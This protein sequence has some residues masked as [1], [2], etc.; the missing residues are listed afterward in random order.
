MNIELEA[1]ELAL[2]LE[3]GYA[4]LAE[5]TSWADEKISTSDNPKLDIIE[6]AFSKK[7]SDAIQHLNNLSKGIDEW[8]LIRVFLK[9][10]RD[11]DILSYADASKL[12]RFLF[13]QSVHQNDCPDDM[14]I[15]HHHSDNIDLAKQGDINCTTEEAIGE[16]LAD[17]KAIAFMT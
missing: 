15:F 7:S 12:A 13:M 11:I 9:R 16:F 1:A 17:V 8:V 3:W 14:I 4:T 2:A 6:V 5:A 10:F